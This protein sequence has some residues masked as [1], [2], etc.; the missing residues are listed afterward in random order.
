LNPKTKSIPKNSNNKRKINS[1]TKNNKN[2]IR[3]KTASPIKRNSLLLKEMS[4][5][6][7]NK[8]S[9]K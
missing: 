1:L 2:L 8:T 7:L 3:N 6:K 9:S 4:N 5:K